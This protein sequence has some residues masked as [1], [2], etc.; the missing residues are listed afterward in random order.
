MERI[1]VSTEAQTMGD[2]IALLLRRL[3]M[4]QM[5]LVRKLKSKG[6]L[7]TKSYMSRII[8]D[9]I[10]NPRKEV[11]FAIADSLDIDMEELLRGNHRPS[12]DSSLSRRVLDAAMTIEDMDEDVK[13][14]V[15]DCIEKAT[16]VDGKIRSL[17]RRAMELQTE[18]ITIKNRARE[19]PRIRARSVADINQ[20][21]IK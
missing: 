3:G 14:Y 1:I 15:L 17:E 9:E 5:Q 4:T 21:S 10:E 11:L 20:F 12:V 19:S 18:I 13:E 6:V 7:V 2:R 16:R 8:Q